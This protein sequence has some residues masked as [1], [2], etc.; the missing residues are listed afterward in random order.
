LS[1]LV[2][3]ENLVLSSARNSD[4]CRADG[5]HAAPD[6]AARLLKRTLTCELVELHKVHRR[7][8]ARRRLKKFRNIGEYGNRYRSAVSGELNSWRAALNAGCRVLRR[9]GSAVDEADVR[10][11]SEVHAEGA[12]D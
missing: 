1:V 10:D 3:Q 7:T 6:E 4:G 11:E 12:D 8:L 2:I 9:R 5:A